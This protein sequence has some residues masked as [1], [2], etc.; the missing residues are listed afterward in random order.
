VQVSG[1]HQVRMR[2]LNQWT[3][4][5]LW[6]VM[7]MINS[8]TIKGGRLSSHTVMLLVKGISTCCFISEPA[9]T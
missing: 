8:A 2:S 3:K 4:S 7:Q 5:L 9:A 1:E 6:S